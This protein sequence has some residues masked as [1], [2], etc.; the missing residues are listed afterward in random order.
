MAQERVLTVPEVAEQL[1]V[2]EETVR[3]WL[4]S[5][6]IRGISLGSKRAGWRIPESEVRRL[7]SGGSF[8]APMT[9]TPNGGQ[10]AR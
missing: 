4:R 3:R 5:G 1:R 8:P 7:L 9:S 6:R 2:T 10:E